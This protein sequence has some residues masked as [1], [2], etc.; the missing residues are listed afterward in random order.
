MT[1]VVILGNSCSNPH[2]GLRPGLLK[3]TILNAD[4]NPWWVTKETRRVLELTN[5][6]FVLRSL[7][8]DEGA[9]LNLGRQGD[10]NIINK[11][12]IYYPTLRS[13]N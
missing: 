13:R 10:T 8:D 3:S 7:G 1:C 5:T 2:P 6:S 9:K 12:G 11:P 4:A